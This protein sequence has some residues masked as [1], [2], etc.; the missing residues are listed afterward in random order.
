MD[1]GY[2]SLKEPPK[3]MPRQRSSLMLLTSDGRTG[4]RRKDCAKGYLFFLY[5]QR[6]RRWR[7][8]PFW[9]LPRER[10][11]RDDSFAVELIFEIYR[12]ELP[13]AGSFLRVCARKEAEFMAGLHPKST[14]NQLI[15]RSV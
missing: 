4:Q 12:G 10:I 13:F 6:I 2:S 14:F 11:R 8:P 1:G 3:K 9:A 15:R 7:L 5:R